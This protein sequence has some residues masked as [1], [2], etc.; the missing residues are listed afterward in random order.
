MRKRG[1][2]VENGIRLA[3]GR[4][5]KQ[6]KRATRESMPVPLP[7]LT[8]LRNSV[9]ECGDC[10][11]KLLIESTYLWAFGSEFFINT[12]SLLSKY[13]HKKGTGEEIPR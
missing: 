8:V 10:H 7:L 4:S 1:N 6:D 11:G 2:V 9:V 13:L 3:S 5:R 12:R